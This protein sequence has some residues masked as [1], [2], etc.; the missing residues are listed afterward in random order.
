MIGRSIS[1][2]RVVER[3]GAG[4]MGVVYKAEDTR[5]GRY[6][7]LKFLSDELLKDP[8]ALERFRRE[9][10]SASALNHPNICTI[11]E[12]DEADGAP[13]LS[14]E[15]L[16]GQ[17]LKERLEQGPLAGE[18]LIDVAIELADALAAAHSANIIHRD[19]KPANLFITRRG[20]V[21]ILDFGLAKVAAD[22]HAADSSRL[23][24]A[25]R[26]LTA[27]DTTIGTVSY[28]SPEQ[29]RGENLDQRSDLFSFGAV[30]YEMTTGTRAF[31]GST[32]AMVY[33]AIFHLDPPPMGGGNASLEPIVAKALQKDRELRYQSAADIRADLKRLRHDSAPA[34]IRTAPAPRKRTRAAGIAFGVVIAAAI[35]GALLWRTRTTLV[36]TSKQT[37]IAVLPFANLGGSKQR[38]YLRLAVPDE[39]VTI[40]SRSKAIAVRPFAMTRKYGGDVDPQEAGHALKVTNVITGDYRDNGGHLAL[41]VEAVDVDQN[42]VLWRDAFDVPA[43]DLI[44]MRNELANRVR[45][46]L[47]PSMHVAAFAP[48]ANKPRND[49]A[50]SVYLRALALSTD[51]QPN[52]Q[53]IELLERAVQLD[54]TYAP[55]W[56]NLS[57]RYYFAFQYALA[58]EEARQKSIA[59][60]TRAASLDPQLVSAQRDLV[61][62]QTEAGDLESA[63]TRAKGMVSTNPNNGDAHFTLAYVLRY[64]GLLDEAA[65]ECDI[66]HSLDPTNPNFR[67]CAIVFSSLNDFPRSEFYL[68][69]DRGSMF[70]QGIHV[71][72]LIFQGRFDEVKPLPH[73][74][75]RRGWEIVIGT[76]QHRPQ[77]EIDGLA[78]QQKQSMYRLR[79]AEPAFAL[80]ET[81][82]IAGRRRD[83]LDLLR[84]AA[85]LNYCGAYPAMDHARAF[86]PLRKDPEFQQARQT[87]IACQQ[88][89]LDWR[90]KN[91]S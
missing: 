40:L 21:K 60:A 70:S 62:P 75:S 90:A 53:A 33:D 10:R 1:H 30:L 51:P 6:V 2:Y 3:L 32:T 46:G 52:A 27:S 73:E 74:Y 18:Q 89:F 79:D 22:G 65:R 8:S 83:A 35:G 38:D 64:A 77:S 7:A 14:M 76:R 39:L 29:A 50:Y 13:F 71:N 67:S 11:Y 25:A 68:N 12:V 15:L 61:V 55:A 85:S 37:T 54:P 57:E 88:R 20:H 44:A 36:H 5:L 81:M 66:A 4:G 48:E 69:L 16:E 31:N 17:T 87:F 43:D 19:L 91:A 24:T 28:M 84:H 9:A 56:A 78:E 82:A 34:T 59:A 41:T 80:A 47:L 42:N 49:E 45:G 58:G 26:D 86:D 23:A 63:Y 72:N